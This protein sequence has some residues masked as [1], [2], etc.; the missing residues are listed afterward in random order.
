MA[1]YL[2]AN[3]TVTDPAR[4][5]EYGRQVAPMIA[6]FG[7]TY[8]VRGGAVTAVE[9]DPGL[10][11][12]VI[13]EFPDMAKLRAFYD[14]PEYAPLIALRQSAATGDVAFVEGYTG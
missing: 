13:V 2:L 8:R 9:G 14:S 5:A 1:A 4:F 10:R 12:V 6:A 7:G 11:R 3:I